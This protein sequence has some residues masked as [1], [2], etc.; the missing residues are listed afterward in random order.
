ML[1]DGQVGAPVN[2]RAFA[3]SKMQLEINR[4][5]RRPDATDI[6]PQDR[7]A[8]LIA[9][10]AQTLK[11]LL[12]AVGVAVKQ[13]RNARLERIKDATARPAAP[14]LEARDRKSTRLNSSH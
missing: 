8:A 11:D 13:S 7:H 2:L 10:L 5:L 1:V 3:G 14:R 9:L 4:P 12:S 6:I